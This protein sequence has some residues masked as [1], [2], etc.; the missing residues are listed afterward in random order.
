MVSIVIVG[1]PT[2]LVPHNA[3][4]NVQQAMEEAYVTDPKN[5]SFALEYFGADLGYLVLMINDTYESSNS[6]LSPFFFWEMF[7]NG[8]VAPKG[9]DS[10]ILQDK[11]IVTF[12]FTVYTTTIPPESTTHAK[13]QARMLQ[14]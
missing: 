9:I 8:K 6:K 13:Y 5:F 7:L 11:D 10:T 4:M 2:I 1:G 12:D 14:N 3:G